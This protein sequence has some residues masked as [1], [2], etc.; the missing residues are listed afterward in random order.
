[1]KLGL[2]PDSVVRNRSFALLWSSQSLSLVGTQITLV[3]LPLTAVVVLNATP[4]QAGVLGFLERLPYLLFAPLIGV[5]V[6]RGR[7]RPLLIGSDA[8]RALLLGSIPVSY[9]LGFLSIGQLFVVAFVIGMMTVVFDVSYQAFLP[10]LVGRGHL[11]EANGRLQISESLAQVAG[12]GL[13]GLLIGVLRPPVVVAIDAI[14]YLVSALSLLGVKRDERPAP[15]P[16]GTALSIRASLRE[17]LD[18]VLRHPVLRWAMIAGAVGNFFFDALT[19][20][21]FLFLIRDVGTGAGGVSLII[22]VGSVGALCGAFCLGPVT[23]FLGTGRSLLVSTALPGVGVLGLAT[24]HGGGIGLVTAAAANFVVLF[25][26]PIYNVTIISLRQAVTPDH[27][28]GRVVATVRMI[29]WGALALGSLAGG[30]L[31]GRIGLRETVLVAGVGL[32]VPTVIL[33]FSPVR[34]MRSVQELS[35]DDSTAS[36]QAAR[37]E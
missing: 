4:M 10:G 26:V 20:V 6:D 25:A 31:G 30:A 13:A 28:L 34:H 8:V 29:S 17:G 5:L 9:G 22:S 2:K 14:S 21:F 7:R 19:A 23:R 24:V 15:P 3:A 18:M 32:F 36:P 11:V 12:P 37:S 33:W 1:M 16:S 27:L 35:D